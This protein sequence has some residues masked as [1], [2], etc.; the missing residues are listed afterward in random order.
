MWLEGGWIETWIL[1]EVG[2]GLVQLMR[3]WVP[4][5]GQLVGLGQVFDGDGGAATVGGTVVRYRR[6]DACH[7]VDAA[8]LGRVRTVDRYHGRIAVVA[9]GARA[10]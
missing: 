1:V 7:L 3:Q 10:C 9:R 6:E 2:C 4:P 8:S 5:D